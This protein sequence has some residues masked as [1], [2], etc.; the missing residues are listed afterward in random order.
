MKWSDLVKGQ[1][2]EISDFRGNKFFYL[3]KNFATEQNLSWADNR[4]SLLERDISRIF[5]IILENLFQHE[6]DDGSVETNL[7]ITGFIMIHN[8]KGVFS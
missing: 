3:A 7:Y 2:T 1:G 8:R 4:Y 5:D 6:Y